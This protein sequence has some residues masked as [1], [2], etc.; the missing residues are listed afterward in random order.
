[1]EELGD[2]DREPLVLTSPIPWSMDTLVEPVVIHDSVDDWPLSIVAGLAD[3]VA[4]G[5]AAGAGGGGG[6]DGGSTGT[7]FLH[8]PASIN[9]KRHRT[10]EA[11]LRY[12]CLFII[13]LL[14]GIVCGLNWIV[15]RT[16]QCRA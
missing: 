15:K 14:H 1:M 9:N 12:F 7:F 16:E 3:R 8:P 6:G 10:T 2:T 13:L 5:A 11:R 4:V